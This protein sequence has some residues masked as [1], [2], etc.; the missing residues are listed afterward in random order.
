MVVT[1]NPPG[2]RER[3]DIA[4]YELPG[5]TGATK[6]RTVK[7]LLESVADVGLR[8]EDMVFQ[9]GRNKDRMDNY[10]QL[11]DFPELLR[12]PIIRVLPV[13]F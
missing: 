10:K 8:A 7:V 11:F 4:S 1:L 5:L 9:Y 13:D 3:F 12:Y 2:A 6:I